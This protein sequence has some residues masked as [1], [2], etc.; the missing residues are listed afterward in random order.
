MQNVYT[1]ETVFFDNYKVP[2]IKVAP[3]F[4]INGYEPP[5][6]ITKSK[7]DSVYYIRYYGAVINSFVNFDDAMQ[8]LRTLCE[9]YE[10]ANDK[11]KC[12]LLIDFD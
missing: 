12:A 7:N 3:T 2:F 8:N 6:I 4:T 9:T 1:Y 5:Y 11:N 10:P